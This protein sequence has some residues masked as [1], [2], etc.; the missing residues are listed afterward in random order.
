MRP[1]NLFL[2][3]AACCFLS[4]SFAAAPRE[5]P[6]DFS[7]CG[8][9][10]G[11]RQIPRV[12]SRFAVVPGGGDDTAVIQKA[13]D[14]ASKLEMGAEGF[15]GA[16][17]LRS[18]TFQVEGEMKLHTSGV[19]IRGEDATIRATGKKRRT[20]LVVQVL[21]GLPWDGRFR[22]QAGQPY[23]RER[24]PFP[25][26][27]WKDLRWGTASSFAVQAPGSGCRPWPWISFR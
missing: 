12:L 23:C 9:A 4:A 11:S 26:P 15:R 19:V 17:L 3:L 16:V 14:Q 18:G 21:R 27:M 13:I 25:S 20:V 10:N 2:A 24:C 8:Y 1:R 7:Y 22:L 5:I 6:I